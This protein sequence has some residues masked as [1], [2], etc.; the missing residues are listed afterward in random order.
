MSW[1][2]EY[3]RKETQQLAEIDRDFPYLATLLTANEKDRLLVEKRL[4]NY[5]RAREQERLQPSI[6]W[7][8][9][10][11]VVID[12]STI[13][14]L[15]C[16]LC[17]QSTAPKGRPRTVLQPKAFD[18]VLDQIKENAIRLDL[19]SW[20][21]PL[22]NPG[23][24]KIV[25]KA[26]G[27]SLYT[28]TSTHFSHSTGVVPLEMVE[29]GLSYIVASIDG[30]S[31]STYEKYRIGG[32][33]KIVLRNLEQ[34]VKARDASG[35]S[36]LIEW[37]YLVMKHN[38][39]EIEDARRTAESIGVDLFRFGGARGVMDKKLLLPSAETV[40]F[41]ADY[42][43]PSDHP[44]S[45]YDATGA[46]KR[47]FE[48]SRCYWLWGKIALNPDGGVSPC[49]SSWFK[50]HDIGNWGQQTI[51]EVWN[52]QGYMN[53]R[54]AAMSG[55]KRDGETVC[56]RCAFHRNFV[57]TPD[58]EGEPTLNDANLMTIL[59]RLRAAGKTPSEQIVRI[60][61]RY[62]E[63]GTGSSDH[64]AIPQER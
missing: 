49:W 12:P 2:T 43:L 6:A 10:Y 22:L 44:L 33:L 64:S 61:Q 13:C 25:R 9:P 39:D 8:L 47:D 45:E 42:L 40:G 14:N 7:A 16:P 20:G 11:H 19:F 60:F 29:S 41:S 18:A 51:A 28:R 54:L 48:T 38:V 53:A 56:E 37:Q 15:R 63:G 27:V 57:F 4:E 50:K 21:E 30:A 36:L 3:L 62:I 52:S 5:C 55:G 26:S 17:V 34:L 31:Q 58:G 24:C 23:L 35:S 46:K 1:F 32:D 59:S